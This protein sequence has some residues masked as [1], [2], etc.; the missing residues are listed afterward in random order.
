MSGFIAGFLVS[1]GSPFL[2]LLLFNL[3]PGVFIRLFLFSLNQV[4]WRNCWKFGKFFKNQVKI[5]KNIHFL[6][7]LIWN[8]FVSGF[9]IAIEPIVWF[10]CSR[11]K[12]PDKICYFRSS[13]YRN[14]CSDVIYCE[15]ERR[16]I[17]FNNQI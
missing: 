6:L 1:I 5:Q 12:A 15:I 3:T 11:L 7:N 17:L 2:L 8:S 4:W 9:P 14:T 16:R 13:F 10:N